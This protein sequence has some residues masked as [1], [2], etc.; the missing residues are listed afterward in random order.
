V[1]AEAM[2]GQRWEGEKDQMVIEAT[3]MDGA[4]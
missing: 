1:E 4:I 3:K 2:A